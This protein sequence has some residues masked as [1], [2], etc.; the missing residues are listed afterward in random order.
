M[1]RK[2]KKQVQQQRQKRWP[3]QTRQEAPNELSKLEKIVFWTA[4]IAA[5]LYILFFW[6]YVPRTTFPSFRG[7]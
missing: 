1:K 3:K 6:K 7:K 4:L 5:A 2:K